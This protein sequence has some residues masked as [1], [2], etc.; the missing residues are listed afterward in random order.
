ME[1]IFIYFKLK[2]YQ[3]NSFFFLLLTIQIIK[4]A[5]RIYFL[6]KYTYCLKAFG[7]DWLLVYMDLSGRPQLVSL[8]FFDGNLRADE[9]FLWNISLNLF[10][11][12]SYHPSFSGATSPFPSP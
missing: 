9:W 1:N 11:S 4:K 12:T 5:P 8:S 6:E 7:I 10:V 2:L 3:L